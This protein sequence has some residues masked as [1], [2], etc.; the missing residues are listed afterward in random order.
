MR[1]FQFFP[2]QPNVIFNM[3]MNAFPR[4][5]GE[6]SY[7]PAIAA[8][9][10]ADLY[11]SVRKFPRIRNA[12]RKES[13]EN[14]QL[15]RVQLRH[16]EAFLTNDVIY[17]CYERG[18]FKFDDFLMLPDGALNFFAAF[19][20][21]LEIL[22][23]KYID[24]EFAA[25]LF[26]DLD[27]D[28]IADFFNPAFIR[29]L[30]TKITLGSGKYHLY[31]FNGWAGKKTEENRVTLIELSKF[32]NHKDGESFV[33]NGFISIDRILSLSKDDLIDLRRLLDCKPLNWIDENY[34][35]VEQFLQCAVN[36]RRQYMGFME[37]KEMPCDH[38]T[39]SYFL[40][41]KPL[42]REHFYFSCDFQNYMTPEKFDAL[43]EEIKEDVSATLAWWDCRNM[44]DSKEITV[45]ELCTIPSSYRK[46]LRR[47]FADVG[48][49]QYSSEF[50]YFHQKMKVLIAKIK[51]HGKNLSVNGEITV[52]EN[53]IIKDEAQFS[54]EPKGPKM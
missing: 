7:V 20:N 40:S 51:A 32:F 43:P 22:D 30:Q 9:A 37:T 16:L 34:L 46:E 41:L 48:G 47:L 36:D 21:A 49:A 13:I 31:E 14:W 25:A 50:E 53:Q 18:L 1:R 6:K 10:T 4:F 23:K 35:T 11:K 26:T 28:Y 27:S 38:F 17:Q 15:E 45:E 39:L 42:T 29:F 3:A 52:C 44:L 5:H 54:A 12:M 33:N 2:V 8:T 19:P 24:F